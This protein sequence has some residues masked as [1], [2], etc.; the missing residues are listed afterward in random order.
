MAQHESPNATADPRGVP[1]SCTNELALASYEK[2]LEQFRTYVGDP[3]ASVEAAL[4]DAPDFS[5]AHVFRATMLVLSSE[6][7][8]LPEARSSLDRADRLPMNDRERTLAQAVRR[9][10]SGDLFGANEAFE[11]VL[12]AY[13]RDCFA[14]QAA[15]L[16]D[17]YVGDSKSLQDRV[18][19]VLP[20]WSEAD[21]EYSY[22]LGM[23][24]F[25]LEECN[26]YAKAETTGRRA[27]EIQ[28]RDGWAVHAVAHVMEMQA[29]FDEGIAWLR[30]REQDWAPDNMFSFHNWWHLALFH[31]E[32]EDYAGA[33]DLFDECI[34]PE[35]SDAS[36]QLLDA[37]ALLWRLELLG[38]DV[39][40]RWR[41]LAADW[42]AKADTENGYYAFNDMHALV[43]YLGVGDEEAGARVIESVKRRAQDGSGSDLSMMARD[44]GV[45]V[46]RALVDYGR[47]HYDDAVDALLAVRR[48][49]SRFGGSHAQ[50]DLI[51]M[52]LIQASLRGG[53]A[54]LAEHL[55]YERTAAKPDSPM[56]RR[57]LAQAQDTLS[58]DVS[59]GSREAIANVA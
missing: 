48:V 30:D 5:L 2:A 54:R 19:R 55:L 33:L 37:S 35:S 21:D 10:A 52:T 12:V 16:T 17:F 46:T 28:P 50:R 42:R 58:N 40:D 34:Y 24:A 8:Y 31:L 15:H 51:N 25:G 29:R 23:Y 43:A 44:V 36:L 27:L 14:L 4:E 18:A 22:I 7:Q 57:W 41:R 1:V 49:A 59:A 45:E 53:N 39:N 26:H 20:H 38:V 32:R 3:V 13:P 11:R 9:W 56:A 6:A 47:G